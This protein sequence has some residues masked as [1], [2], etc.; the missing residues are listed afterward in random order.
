MQPAQTPP[1]TR[2]YAIGDIHGMADKLTDLLHKIQADAQTYTGKKVLIFLGDYIDRGLKS[3]ETLEMI[4]TLNWPNWKKIC[5]MG[6]HEFGCLTF[7]NAPDSL[8]Q[9]ASDWG[10]ATMLQSYRVP[11]AHSSKPQDLATKLTAQMPEH[12]LIFLKNLPLTHIEGDY[13]FVHA[14]VKNHT[15]LEEQENWDLMFI[16]E[17]EFD[18]RIPHNLPYKVVY[19]HRPKED[20]L[21]TQDRICIDTGAYKPNGKLTAAILEDDSIRFLQA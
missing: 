6:N 16:R 10:G 11:V 9:W 3:R 1:N 8:P 20:P 7:L 13:L 17:P 18:P 2:I 14:G 15:P 19:G 5:L 4:S 12:H 21:N